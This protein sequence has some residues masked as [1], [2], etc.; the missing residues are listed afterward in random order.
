MWPTPSRT[1]TFAFAIASC[2]TLAIDASTSRILQPVAAN[3][4][5][6]TTNESSPASYLYGNPKDRREFTV[7]ITSPRAGLTFTDSEPVDVRLRI[8]AP[9]ESTV[10][11]YAVSETEGPWQNHGTLVFEKDR[12]EKP[13]PLNLPG[14]GLFQLNVS[15]K[16]GSATSTAVTWVAVVFTPDTVMPTSPW[17]IM[18]LPQEYVTGSEGNRLAPTD[19]ARSKRLLGASWTRLANNSYPLE[20]DRITVSKEGPPTVTADLSPEMTYTRA[21][22]DQGLLVMADVE[23]IPRI[24]SSKPDD[25]VVV[26][27]VPGFADVPPKDYAV[28]ERF[29]ETLATTYRGLVQV[30]QIGNEPDLPRQYWKG[31]PEEFVEFV[32]HTAIG[33]RRGDPSVRVAAPGFSTTDPA[34][35][36]ERLFQ[37]GLGKHID[38]LTVH[39]T[40]E[41][42]DLIPRWYQLL[43]QYKLHIPIWNSE[44]KSVIPFANFAGGLGLFIKFLHVDFTLPD[45]NNLVRTDLTVR[46]AGIAFSVGAHCIGAARWTKASDQMVSG[47]NVDFFQ[48][49]DEKIVSL[50]RLPPPARLFDPG[51]RYGTRVTLT[52]EPIAAGRPVTATNVWGR[53]RVLTLSNG[54]AELDLTDDLI[55]INGARKLEIGRVDLEPE[56]R[57]IVVEAEVGRWSPGWS[58]NQRSGGYSGGTVLEIWSDVDPGPEGFWAEAKFRLPARGTFELIFAGSSL[59]ALVAG[60]RDVSPFVWTVDDGAEHIVDTPLQVIKN[61]AGAPQGISV[62][63][64]VDLNAG[65]HTFRLRLLSRRNVPDNR[66]SL[67]FDAIALRPMLR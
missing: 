7:W 18:A 48:R 4:A 28:W 24:F 35:Y 37:L 13:L 21:L 20:G 65:E 22:H 5:Q 39:Y 8:G 62:L 64:T 38:I 17:G 59:R 31:T 53:S 14:R 32:Q 15:A 29:M 6:L 45:Y 34:A 11:D 19:I 2:L 51:W 12:V 46:P 63:D 41:R 55:F 10:V 67:W 52:V 26:G 61:V 27:D 50:R 49:G 40:D 43:E 42:S 9:A 44:E 57:A 30:W 56:P 23:N 36:A 66:W 58:V 25:N 33:L 54:R 60:N 3:A 1:S 47:W 16:S